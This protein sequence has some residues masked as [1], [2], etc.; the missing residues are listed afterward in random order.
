MDQLNDIREIYFQKGFFSYR[1]FVSH[2][3]AEILGFIK[4]FSNNPICC[5][6]A[7]VCL[8]DQ[9]LKITSIAKGAFARSPYL[10]KI[11]YEENSNLEIIKNSAFIECSNLEELDL[12][13]SVKAIE[14]QVFCSCDLLTKI[15]IEEGSCIVP[16]LLSK[17]WSFQVMD[18]P[19]LY[20]MIFS[21]INSSKYTLVPDF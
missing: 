8:G 19:I 16:Q 10:K 3:T 21:K 1:F 9:N 11:N 20:K 12:P 7:M 17:D 5:I 2:Q 4:C 15:T 14:E 6:P 18:K 13:K